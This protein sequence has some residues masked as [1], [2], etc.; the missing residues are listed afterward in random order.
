ME[1]ITLPNNRFKINTDK[2]CINNTHRQPQAQCL[3]LDLCYEFK[4]TI[5]RYYIVIIELN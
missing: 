3:H 1:M 5:I 2:M 4:I